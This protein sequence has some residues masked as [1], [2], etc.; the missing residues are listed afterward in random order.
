[1]VI[2]HTDMHPLASI[3]LSVDHHKTSFSSDIKVALLV[4]VNVTKH[5]TKKENE[6]QADWYP[7]NY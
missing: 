3:L 7:A 4:I 6:T 1:M 5:A 2:S